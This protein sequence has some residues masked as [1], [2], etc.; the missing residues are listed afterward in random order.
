[1][2]RIQ[3]TLVTIPRGAAV[4]DTSLAGKG[5]LVTG[6]GSGIGAATAAALVERG[7]RVLVC[8][9]RPEPLRRVAAGL[10]CQWLAADSTC[11]AD[12]QA[13][14]AAILAT[15]TLD[16]VV[17]CA[18]TMLSASILQTTPADWDA[19]LASNAGS[20]FLLVREALPHLIATRGTVVLVSSIA[21]LRSSGGS[22]AYAAAKAAMVS[23]SGAVAVEHGP[24]GVRSNVVC[25]GWVR[26]EMAD[27]EM[28]ALNPAD[29]AAG[30]AEVTGL[31]PQR[32][33]AEPAEVAAAVAWL[34]SPAAS[35]VNGAVLTVDGGATVV[36]AGTVPFD[37]ALSPRPA[38]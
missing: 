18:G 31:V 24:A 13:A 5:Y 26:T 34:S 2:V 9:R 11:A 17:A 7:A 22:A 27:A 29:R 12:V 14:V 16:G 36:D 25:P 3:T 23:L 35:Y 20:A 19:C 33:P 6:G 1:M 4:P 8:G 10:G 30:Y 21:A 38:G 28:D 37:F 15:G 32:R